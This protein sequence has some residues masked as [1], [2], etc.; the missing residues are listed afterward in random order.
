MD[1]S[2][3]ILITICAL[4]LFAAYKMVPANKYKLLYIL[5]AFAALLLRVATVM[6]IYRGGTDTFG[7]DGLLY[8]NEGIL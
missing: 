6:Y 5:L 2:I 3:I 4:S 8:H 7:T 1:S